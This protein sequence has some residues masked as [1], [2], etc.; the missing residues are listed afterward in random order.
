MSK[1]SLSIP[2]CKI[3]GNLLPYVH[4]LIQIFLLTTKNMKNKQKEDKKL[5]ILVKKIVEQ[6]LKEYGNIP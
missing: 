2:K 6:T 3:C 5:E 1:W 4:I